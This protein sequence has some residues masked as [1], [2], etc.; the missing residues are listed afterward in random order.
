MDKFVVERF[1]DGELLCEETV[2]CDQ[3]LLN[4]Q[5]LE[6]ICVNHDKNIVFVRLDINTNMGYFLAADGRWDYGTREEAVNEI[7]RRLAELDNG[8]KK[9]V[10][11]I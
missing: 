4:E 7:K 9:E 11:W 6:V 8:F 2:G 5:D 1:V 10:T 3:R